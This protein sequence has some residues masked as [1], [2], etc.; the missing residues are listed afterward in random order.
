MPQ[1]HGKWFGKPV[2]VDFKEPVGDC[3]PHA[4]LFIVSVVYHFVLPERLQF[5]NAQRNRNRDNMPFCDSFS[6]SVFVAVH[7]GIVFL[8][9]IRI[10]V[11]IVY[12]FAEC[13]SF[14]L[15]FVLC[16][17]DDFNDTFSVRM[18]LCKLYGV[19]NN[20]TVSL[21]DTVAITNSV[22]V[23]VSVDDAFTVR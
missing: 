6:V 1:L 23:I 22:A 8:H 20:N 5:R 4:I 9:S 21:F 19:C 14:S 18:L 10:C 3:E 16:L 13:H 7:D 2:A 15:P 17:G 11:R 12:F